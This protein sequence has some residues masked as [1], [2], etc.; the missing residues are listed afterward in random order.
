MSESNEAKIRKTGRLNPD[1]PKKSDTDQTYRSVGQPISRDG[2][3]QPERWRLRFDVLG[4][5]PAKS[6]GLD[7]HGDVV[8]GR[9][10]ETKELVDLSPYHATESGVSREHLRLH[11]ENGRL[12]AIDLESTNGT[13]INGLP[14]SKYTPA[15]LSDQDTLQLGNFKLRI[16]FVDVPSTAQISM[17]KMASL[18]DALSHLAKAITSRLKF[19]EVMIQILDV[20][21]SLTAAGQASI[22]LADSETGKITREVA[23]GIENSDVQHMQLPVAGKSLVASVI[24][25]G[26][27]LRKSRR[28]EGDQIK[29]KTGYLVEALLYIPLTLGSVTFGVLEVTHRQPG[30]SFTEKDEKLLTAIGDF[31]AIAI[32]NARA[33]KT[34]QE[35]VSQRTQE[36][37]ALNRLVT[38]TA[39]TLDLQTVLTTT[40]KHMRQQ[41]PQH[42]VGLWM[43][44]EATENLKP[45]QASGKTDGVVDNQMTKPDKEIIP[46]VAQQGKPFMGPISIS[47]RSSGKDASPS[48]KGTRLSDT[49]VTLATAARTVAGAPLRGQG[50]NV[51][52]VIA[53]FGQA[54]LELSQEDFNLLQS[55]ASHVSS[56]IDNAYLYEQS[57]RERATIRILT[58][59]LAQPLLIVNE[60]GKLVIANEAADALLEGIWESDSPTEQKSHP[61]LSQ[62][63]ETI[64]QSV[65]RVTELTI[66]ERAYVATVQQKSSVGTII[67]MQDVTQVRQLERLRVEVA[68]ALSHDLRGLL[69]S[70]IGYADFLSDPSFTR[71]QI[72]EIAGFMGETA[73]RMNEMVSHLLDFAMLR[74][75]TEGAWAPVD[76]KAAVNNA[77][78]DLRGA[79]LAKSVTID[80]EVDGE[81]LL[82][83][84]DI[85]RLYRSVLNLIDNALKY[86]SSDSKILVRLSYKEDAIELTVR[87]FGPGVPE[88]ELSL[89][90]EK[91]YRAQKDTAERAGIGL[92]LAMV[93]ATVEGHGGHVTVSNP[94]GGGAKFTIVLPATDKPVP[95]K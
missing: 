63:L 13:R 33:Y 74:E 17:A 24:K 49:D 57:E 10:D 36:L 51:K 28:L 65:D 50:A 38:E 48:E 82:V 91:Y 19:E 69:T 2:E 92:G 85:N 11:I 26:K 61:V 23:R 71:D 59:S 15:D 56:A 18:A 81:P 77:V 22:W 84:G 25:S 58:E 93:K 37:A 66:G 45:H 44:D 40:L 29:I 43:V 64:R 88:D 76:F 78:M 20:S 83:R 53:V 6:F 7:I 95:E 73:R 86:S 30:A 46:R 12:F 8:L 79:T 14:I 47:T 67:I 68:Q 87:D 55:F 4:S 16:S 31:A 21:M 62:I 75:S 42:P 3:M 39:A 5:D 90:F 1:K 89:I 32:S 70:I 94:E 52:G 41:W 34:A 27:V 9:G 80:F 72:E 60:S 54:D 35:M